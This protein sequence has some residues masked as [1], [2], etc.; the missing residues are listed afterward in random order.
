MGKEHAQAI[1]EQEIKYDQLVESKR[2]AEA[3]VK[4]LRQRVEMLTFELD[5]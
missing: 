1:R 3:E 5:G 4:E 2:G